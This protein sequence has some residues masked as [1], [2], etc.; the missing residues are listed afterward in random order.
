MI[1]T[2]EPNDAT[3]RHYGVN[4]ASLCMGQGSPHARLVE[5][6]MSKPLIAR[7]VDVGYGNTKYTTGHLPTDDGYAASNEFCEMFPSLTPTA[8]PNDLSA[9]LGQSRDTVRIDLEGGERFEVGR[10]VRLVLGGG[11]H[12]RTLDEN[13]CLSSRYL[14]LVL[15]ALSYM[16]VDEVDCLVLGLPLTT[17]QSKREALENFVAGEHRLNGKTLTIHKV[18]VVPQPMGG[19][20][21]YVIQ[22]GMEDAM[23]H[24]KNLIIDPGYY[25]L[26]WVTSEGKRP[27]DARSA[28]VN[29]SG[30]STILNEVRAAIEHDVQKDPG[31]I[32]R[33]DEAIRLGRPLKVHGQAVDLDK[34]RPLIAQQADSAL[35]KLISG[36][37]GVADIDNVIVVGGA[38]HLYLDAIKARF[39]HHQVHVGEHPVF[40]NVRGFQMLGEAWL[41]KNA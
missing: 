4:A 24:E 16:Q 21:D 35:N 29:D 31:D 34:Y 19:F 11:A 12:D 27:I 14:A 1:R 30:A 39:P 2:I 3:R 18:S 26:D 15:G 41:K 36:A 32:S 17:Y 40:A 33:I 9:T 6:R 38:T 10:E 8:L 20:Y 37:R 5:N 22:H 25:T 28:A 23:E 13:F 7:A